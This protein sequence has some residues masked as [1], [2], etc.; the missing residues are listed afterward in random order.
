[1][2]SKLQEVTRD[3]NG[4]YYSKLVGLPTV[5]NSALGETTKTSEAQEK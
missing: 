5:G 2:K 3:I 1:M 4:V